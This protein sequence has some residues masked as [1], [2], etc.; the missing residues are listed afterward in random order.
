[1]H[2]TQIGSIASRHE[3]RVLALDNNTKAALFAVQSRR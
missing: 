2:E 1:M 3:I